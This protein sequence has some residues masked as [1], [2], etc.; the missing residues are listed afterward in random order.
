M[1]IFS[2]L[3]DWRHAYIR[4]HGD[5]PRVIAITAEE[6][7]EAF[8]EDSYSVRQYK[9]GISSI[10]GIN[11]SIT[12]IAEVRRVQSLSVDR[13]MLE[14]RFDMY[15]SSCTLAKFEDTHRHMIAELKALICVDKTR[16]TVEMENDFWAPLK[17]RVKW[18]GKRWPIRTKKVEV[19]C[20]VFYPY[21]KLT[22]PEN[23]SHV[24]FEVVG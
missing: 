24:R 2:K 15:N 17:R 20:K 14:E 3:F 9:S 23:T 18:M 4:V 5:D 21:L 19:D 11:A 10:F 16:F 13:I 7:E 6:Q 8:N 12:P 22:L 1:S